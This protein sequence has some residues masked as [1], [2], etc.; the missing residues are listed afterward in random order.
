MHY[1]FLEGKWQIAKYISNVI[2]SDFIVVI[3]TIIFA[4]VLHFVS[5]KLVSLINYRMKVT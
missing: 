3:I 1:W 2:F 5:Q 4:S